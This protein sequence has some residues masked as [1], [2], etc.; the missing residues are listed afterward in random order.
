[1]ICTFLEIWNDEAAAPHETKRLETSQ[2]S[3]KISTR[4]S[5]TVVGP[6][7][8]SLLTLRCYNICCWL[9]IIVKAADNR[10]KRFL[11]MC[12]LRIN[13]QSFTLSC[14]ALRD[15]THLKMSK[16][17]NTVT[18]VQIILKKTLKLYKFCSYKCL[19]LW[20]MSGFM[21]IFVRWTSEMIIS[22]IRGSE[23][24]SHV[25]DLAGRWR[26][27]TINLSGQST[28]THIKL[29]LTSLLQSDSQKRTSWVIKTEFYRR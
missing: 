3:L 12:L 7:A 20:F 10:L 22:S 25:S 13:I 16:N 19:F 8:A 6:S 24:V 11:K 2:T 17:I 15:M 26:R 21:G 9:I 29:S 4:V 5:R 1:M 14:A 27:R 23:N 18:G 28:I